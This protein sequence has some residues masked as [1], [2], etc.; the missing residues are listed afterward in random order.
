[1][2][3][4]AIIC[5]GLTKRFTR[6]LG[7]STFTAVEDLDLDVPRGSTFGLLG[8]NGAGKTTTIQMVLG[9]IAPSAGT[10]SVLGGS[11]RSLDVRRRI[12]FVPEKFQLPG[13]LTAQEYLEIHGSMAGLDGAARATR[14]DEVLELVNLTDRRGDRLKGFSKGMQ[15]RT[16]LAQALLPR[17]ELLI[18][19]EPTS[20]LDP[21][22]R[23][24]VREIIVKSQ[25]EGTTIVLNSHIL[26]EVEAV[27]DQVAI[28]QKGRVVRQGTIAEL[29]DQRVRA[30]LRVGKWTDDVAAAVTPLVRDQS[31][32]MGAGNVGNLQVTVDTH[33]K[34][35][36][37]SVAI[38]GAG[39]LLY[40]MIPGH[41]SLEDMFIRIVGEEVSAT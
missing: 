32:Q 15:Q 26:S 14:V 20:A 10:S 11:I 18:L 3:D 21:F 17:P 19:D 40:A 4:S 16:M 5:S 34:L 35:P 29:G 33:D 37:L 8:P 38:A 23:R 31:F 25:G 2:S 22:G 7:R 1:V 27:C 24:E 30:E 9:L 12:G 39:G 41:E 6:R 28:L 36:E 13:Y